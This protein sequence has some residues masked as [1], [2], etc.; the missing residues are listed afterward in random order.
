MKAVMLSIQ[1]Q[2]CEKIA[3]RDK[4]LE[5]RKTKPNTPTPFR[6]YIY[7][8][9]RN[10]VYKLLEKLRSLAWVRTVME[11]QGKVIGEFICD[12]IKTITASDFIVAEDGDRAIEGSCLTRQEVKGYAGWR[13]GVPI[14]ECKDLYGWHISDLVIYDKPK[15]LSDFKPWNR[16]CMYSDLGLAIPNCKD[17]HACKI[18]RAPQSWCYV[19]EV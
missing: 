17:C 6:C 15:L 4:S 9:R 10:W 19:D 12:Y 18:K 3:V 7:Q 5:I 11:G 14:W 8:T 13:R 2:W 16:E 1:P